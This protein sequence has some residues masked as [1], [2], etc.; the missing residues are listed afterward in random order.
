M[1][2]ADLL[3]PLPAGASPFMPL[4][5]T[6][7]ECPTANSPG[8]T[9]SD[10]VGDKLLSKSWRP[11][12]VDG[13]IEGRDA[14]DGGAVRVGAAL[15]HHL[16]EVKVAVDHR[17]DERRGVVADLGLVDVGAGVEER[18]GGVDVAFTGGK[19]E[20]RHAAVGV[21][22]LVAR[23]V[24]VHARDAR[25]RATS[26]VRFEARERDGWTTECFGPSW[27]AFYGEP[28]AAPAAAPPISADAPAI[29]AELGTALQM[30]SA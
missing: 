25:V 4:I 29:L 3:V 15:E 18:P 16:R 7:T 2:A 8:I 17:F 6:T 14:V 28:A 12:D 22:Q 26:T 1:A 21:D 27:F 13:G 24:P 19:Q 9:C 5:H 10:S 11:L 30:W 23:E 20:R